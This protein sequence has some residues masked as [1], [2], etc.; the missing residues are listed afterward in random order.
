[1]T[2]S[3][4]ARDAQAPVGAAPRPLSE[5]RPGSRAIITAVG[6]S[7]PAAPS[8]AER[9]LTRRLQDLGIMPG[10]PIKV[11]RRAPLGDPTVFLVADYELCLR[12]RDAALIQV[13][14]PAAAPGSGRHSGPAAHRAPGRASTAGRSGQEER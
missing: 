13:A 9:H 6:P 2:T 12:K 11:L 5:L 7:G 1:M 10:R 14:D 3:T 4:Q 8:A